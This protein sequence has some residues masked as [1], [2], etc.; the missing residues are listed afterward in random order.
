MI[1]KLAL[2]KVRDTILSLSKMRVLALRH[3]IFKNF[4][5]SLTLGALVV[6]LGATSSTVF[7]HDDNHEAE[8]M[9]PDVIKMFDGFKPP[10]HPEF[11]GK[12]PPPPN[13]VKGVRANAKEGDYALLRGFFIERLDETTFLF[14]DENG[15]SLNVS[16][17]GVQI[18]LDLTFNYPYFLWGCV[19]ENDET[20]LIQAQFLSP[21]Q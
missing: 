4:G 17:E 15:D 12:V 19:L 8:R 3:N 21:K 6:Q 11:K 7:A 5:K 18:P 9:T 20:T 10:H 1:N 2:R 13:T 16:F 14:K